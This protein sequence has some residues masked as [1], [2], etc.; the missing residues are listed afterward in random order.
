LLDQ[1][2]SE[3]FTPDPHCNLPKVS[4]HEVINEDEDLELNKRL[5]GGG[6]CTGLDLV[7]SSQM[8]GPRLIMRG[9]E[10]AARFAHGGHYGFN[11]RNLIMN[12]D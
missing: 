4:H 1:G 3:I 6:G 7:A 5:L 9:Q 10:E 12:S 8:T 11:E 2:P